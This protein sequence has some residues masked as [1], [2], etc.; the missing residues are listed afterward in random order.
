MSHD[1]VAKSN[2]AAMGGSWALSKTP[3]KGDEDEASLNPASISFLTR[4]R[5]C[6]GYLPQTEAVMETG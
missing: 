3:A 6:G 2:K 5:R 1:P 4:G